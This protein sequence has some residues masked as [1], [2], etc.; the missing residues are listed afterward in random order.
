[1]IIRILESDSVP[2]HVSLHLFL[3]LTAPVQTRFLVHMPHSLASCY[4]GKFSFYFLNVKYW[5][6]RVIRH[7]FATV[8]L[9]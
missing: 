7:T 3:W 4:L 6:R 2:G 1:M 9:L 8:V 5:D